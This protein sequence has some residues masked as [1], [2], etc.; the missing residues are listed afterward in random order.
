MISTIKLL[1]R[2]QSWALK[3]LR[4][5]FLLSGGISRI[6]DPLRPVVC[7]LRCRWDSVIIST[8]HISGALTCPVIEMIQLE[9]REMQKN[10]QSHVEIALQANKEL[11]YTG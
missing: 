9:A 2:F 1:Y 7:S 8:L 10:P 6:R 3:K 5:V 4:R 11:L